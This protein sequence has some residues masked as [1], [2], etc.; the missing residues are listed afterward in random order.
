MITNVV[1]TKAIN[2]RNYVID[3]STI[4]GKN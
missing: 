4:V 3:R 1:V 2:N